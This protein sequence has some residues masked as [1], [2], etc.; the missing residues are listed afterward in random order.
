MEIFLEIVKMATVSIALVLGMTEFTKQFVPDGA[1]KNQI[2]AVINLIEGVVITILF[3]A[4]I[5]YVQSGALL[6]STMLLSV[7]AGLIAGLSAGKF[8]DLG[9]YV[10]TK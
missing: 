3:Q 9:K 1:N 4:T 10:A 5:S 6:T 8:F 7:W 2:I